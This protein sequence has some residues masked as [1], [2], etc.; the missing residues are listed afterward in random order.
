MASFSSGN[1]DFVLMSVHIRCGKKAADRIKP[2]KILAEWV[3]KRR[4]DTYGTDNDIILMGD[5]N[6]PSLD[7]EL[8]KAIIVFK[9]NILG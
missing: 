4:K 5:F 6:I 2:L 1:F 3:E 8:Y 7:S 9:K